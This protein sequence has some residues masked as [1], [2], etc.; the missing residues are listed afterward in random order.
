MFHSFTFRYSSYLCSFFVI[1]RIVSFFAFFF[2]FVNKFHEFVHSSCRSFEFLIYI[3]IFP[4]FCFIFE[5]QFFSFVY[6]F[7]FLYMCGL[8]I[9]SE[10]KDTILCQ[11]KKS[12]LLRL[13]QGLQTK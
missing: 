12:E 10:L 1:P 11:Q 13:S 7:C 4:R 8:Y 3:P 2:F 9:T 5:K 6:S